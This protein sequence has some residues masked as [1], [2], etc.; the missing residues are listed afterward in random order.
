MIYL[1]RK[2]MLYVGVPVILFC[3]TRIMLPFFAWRI[4]RY[5]KRTQRKKDPFIY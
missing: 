4:G 3:V 5:I 2:F 1:K